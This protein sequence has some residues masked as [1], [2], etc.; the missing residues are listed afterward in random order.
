M[1][2]IIQIYDEN[3]KMYATHLNRL[4]ITGSDWMVLVRPVASAVATTPAPDV[5][6]PAP[7]LSPSTICSPSS[8]SFC[9][10][11]PPKNATAPPRTKSWLRGCIWSKKSKY[12]SLSVFLAR[13]AYWST[14]LHIYNADAVWE[15]SCSH[16]IALTHLMALI[17]SAQTYKVQYIL[18]FK[19]VHSLSRHPMS[20]HNYW[21][22]CCDA[23]LRWKH[24]EWGWRYTADHIA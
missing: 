23:T 17:I 9:I 18:Y 24:L 10:R 5:A 8:F 22:R 11:S 2:M 15:E 4:F 13:R 6:A 7:N 14:G 3:F 1:K 16:L 20:C 21:N 12:L 19:I